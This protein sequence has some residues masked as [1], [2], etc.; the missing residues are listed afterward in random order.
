M[1]KDVVELD[2]NTKW[3]VDYVQFV[4]SK[5]PVLSNSARDHAN[6]MEDLRIIENRNQTGEKN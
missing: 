2:K 1:N 4:D 6:K 5:D 3:I